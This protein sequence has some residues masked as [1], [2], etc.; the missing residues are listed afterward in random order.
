M[1]E[2]GP[3]VEIERV[4]KHLSVPRANQY[5]EQTSGEAGTR[6]VEKTGHYS[7]GR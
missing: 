2:S 1:G 4:G 3:D 6:T 5:G 7:P